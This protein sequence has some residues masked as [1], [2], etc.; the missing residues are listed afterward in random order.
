MTVAKVEQL[1]EQKARASRAAL[2]HVRA[3]LPRGAVLGVGTGSTAATFI[4][5][6][7]PELGDRLAGFVASSEATRRALAALGLRVLDLNEVGELPL[8]VDGADQI[9]PSLQMLKGGGGALVREKIVAAAAR[10]FVCIADGSKLVPTLGAA[11]PVE[12][13]PM[14]RALVSR[15]VRALGGDARLRE[16]FV[17]DNGNP[18][19]DVHALDLRRPVEMEGALEDLV[20]VVACGLFAR[21]TADRLLLADAHGVREMTLP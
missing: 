10:E 7:L 11:V 3:T 21:R 9:T 17:S 8:Y 14:A 2:E 15:G 1:A 6:L 16:G 5:L 4:A 19:L 20:G 18:I 12:V 13:I